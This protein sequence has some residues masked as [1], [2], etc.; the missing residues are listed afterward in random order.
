MVAAAGI[1]VK[2]P[3]LIGIFPAALPLS[4]MLAG[5]LCCLFF[6]IYRNTLFLVF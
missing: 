5:I 2:F 6:T 1:L 3:I 4:I